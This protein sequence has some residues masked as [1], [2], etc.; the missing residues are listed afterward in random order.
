MVEYATI[1]NLVNQYLYGQLD[2][3]SDLRARLRDLP[4]DAT[5]RL[6]VQTAT[7]MNSVGR[8]AVPSRAKAVQDFFSGRIS[9]SLGTT[10]GNGYTRLT[11]ADAIARGVLSGSDLRIEVSNYFTDPGS[12]DY[13]ER[14]FIWGGTSYSIGLETT[15]VWHEGNMF[16]ENMEV[17]PRIPENFDFIASNQI[18]QN[19]NETILEPAID[20]YRIG[21]KV[22]LDFDGT[23]G[24]VYDGY[25]DANFRLDA[26]RVSQW[27][28][29]TPADGLRATSEAIRLVRELIASGAIEYVRDDKNIIYDSPRDDVLSPSDWKAPPYTVGGSSGYIFVAGKGDDRVTGSAL[30]DVVYGGD[31]ADSVL[32]GSGDD[33][34]YGGDQDDRLLG[35]AGKDE[36]YG[37]DGDDFLDGGAD[38]DRLFGGKDNDLISGG[39]GDDIINGEDG[40]DRLL[41]DNGR[42]TIQGGAGDDLIA[43]GD[44]DDTI[45]GGSGNDRITGD[46]GDDLVAGGTGD[47]IIVGDFG[48]DELQ[49]GADNDM[50][51][52]GA[53]NDKLFG[54]AGRDTLLGGDNSD[55]LFGG[56]GDDIL[57]GGQS[58]DSFNG[59]E[60]DDILDAA[61]DDASMDALRG[62]SGRDTFIVNDGDVILDLERGDKGVVIAGLGLRGGKRSKNDSA[63]LY[64]GSNGDTYLLRGS[65]LTVSARGALITIQ[66]FSNGAGGIK[67][68]AKDPN[69]DKKKAEDQASPIVVDLDGDGIELV[70]LAQSNVVFDVDGDG[71]AERT[72]WVGRDD[73][74]LV[75]DLGNDG[76]IADASEIFGTTPRGRGGVDT[77]DFRSGFDDLAQFDSDGDGKISSADA[78]FGE[79]KIWRD[80][81]QDG[82]SDASEL[83][84][85]TEVGIQSLDLNYVR[86]NRPLSDGNTLFDRSRATRSDGTTVEVSDVFFAVDR[87][88]QNANDIDV[89]DIDPGVVALPFLIGQGTVKDLDVAMSGDPLLKQM[90]SDLAALDAGRLGEFMP[91]VMDIVLRWTGADKADVEGRGFNVN[92]QWMAALE[93][94]TGSPFSQGGTPNPRPNAGSISNQSINDFFGYAAASLFVQL[95]VAQ[96]AL[97]GMKFLGGTQIEVDLGTTLASL[98]S[99]A[100]LKAPTE[101]TDK[102]AYWQLVIRTLETAAPALGV[103]NAAIA[104]AISPE[105]AGF[106]YEQVRSAIWTTERSPEAIG[107]GGFQTGF[108]P[109]T[110]AGTGLGAEY[111]DNLHVIRGGNVEIKDN[112]GSDT[113]YVGSR[114]VRAT[115]TDAVL[116]YSDTA[117]SQ[118]DTL[119]FSASRYED[120][121]FSVGTDEN[122]DSLLVV[123][124][125]SRN[126]AISIKRA[127][128]SPSFFGNGNVATAI[129]KFVF[130]D[131]ATKDIGEIAADVGVL[132]ATPYEDILYA[133]SDGS[134]LDGL[135]GNDLLVGTSNSNAF[136]LRA[137]GDHDQISDKFIG[138]TDRLVIDA[139][140]GT[141]AFTLSNDYDRRD[142]TVTLA[143]GESVT[144]QNQNMN[145]SRVIQRFVFADGSELNA[146][147]ATAL[148]LNATARDETII[149]TAVADVIV[150]QG[151]DDRLEG[152]GGDD[153]YVVDANSGHD[154][155]VDRGN[156]VVRF[157]G[158]AFS[159]VTVTRTGNEDRDIRISF[160]NAAASLTLD[161]AVSRSSREGVAS[162]FV[163]S[164]GVYS[165]E[166]VL[167][168]AP[169]LG[170]S[171]TGTDLND[172][173]VGTVGDDV[174]DGRAGNDVLTDSG[175]SDRY[176]FGRGSGA[177]IIRDTGFGN[178]AIVL[179]SGISLKDLSF[180][181]KNGG[182]RIVLNERDNL[183]LEGYFAGSTPA[184]EVLTIE[185]RT[186]SLTTISGRGGYLDPPLV[187]TAGDDLIAVNP[188]YYNRSARLN[189][190]GG[191]DV[192]ADQATDTTI[193]L[194]ANFGTK[195]VSDGD[196]SDTIEF[197]PGIS[198]DDVTLSRDDRDLVITVGNGGGTVIWKHYFEASATGR[199]SMVDI[200]DGVI[201]GDPGRGNRVLEQLVFADGTRID[202]DR[203]DAQFIASTAGNDLILRQDTLDGGGG[204]DLLEGDGG[205]NSYIFGR[206]YGH[207]I[208]RDYESPDF[209][210]SGGGS[211]SGYGYGYGNQFTDTVI[212]DGLAL[213]D[214]VL[215]RT[216][217]QGEDLKFTVIAT[218]AT[219]T[220]DREHVRSFD[221][222]TTGEIEYFSFTDAYLSN[223]ELTALIVGTT[224]GDDNI[225]AVSARAVIDTLG[226]GD[227]VEAGRLGATVLVDSKTTTDTLRFASA[228][229]SVA[230]GLS[231]SIADYAPTFL[232]GGGTITD[233]VPVVRGDR[234]DLVIRFSGGG[235]L[236][237]EGGIAMWLADGNY[238]S[239]LGTVSFLDRSYDARNII[240][241]AFRPRAG[242]PFDD[243]IMGTRN[244]DVIDATAGNDAIFTIGGTTADTVL[245]GRGDGHDVVDTSPFNIGS[246]EGRL[247]IQLKAGIRRGDV[248]FSATSDGLVQ[249]ELDGGVDTLSFNPSLGDPDVSGVLQG[250]TTIVF[251]DGTTLDASSIVD[252]LSR[253]TAGNDVII[254]D[255]RT[256]IVDGGAGDDVIFLSN[257]GDEFRFGR[258]SG[259]DTIKRMAGSQAVANLRFGIG[260]SLGNLDFAF[261]GGDE[262]DLVISISGSNDRLTIEDF[263]S[264]PTG[265]AASVPVNQFAFSDGTVLSWQ[266]IA[267]MT[268]GISNQGDDVVHGNV[269]G[270][271][272]AGGAGN[273]LLL[274][275]GGDDLYRFGRGDQSDTIVDRGGSADTIRFGTNIYPANAIFSRPSD[276]PA[277]LLIEIDGDERLTLTVRG[278]F[279]DESSRIELFAFEDGTVLG[280]QDVQ[281]LIL[282]DSITRGNDARILGYNGD[283][284]IDALSGDDFV[285]G[286]KG[287]DRLEGGTGIDTADFSGTF[288]QYRIERDGNDWIVTDLV[289]GRDGTDRLHGFEFVRFQGWDS[290]QLDTRPVAWS[291]PSI[292]LAGVEDTRL[293]IDPNSILAQVVNPDGAALSIAFDDSANVWRLRDGSYAA[294]PPRDLT[295]AW[296]VGYSV[297]DG[298]GNAQYGSV[299][300]NIVPINDA[301][302]ARTVQVFGIEDQVIEGTVGVTDADGDT[303]AYAIAQ[304][305]NH[306]TV[307]LDAATGAYVYTPSTD[308]NGGDSFTVRVTDTAGT[309]SVSSIVVS[310]EPVNDAPLVARPLL[311]QSSPEDTAID[312]VIPATS[313][314]DVD[315][316]A[317][318][319]TATLP[320]GRPLPSWLT[321]NDSTA[322]FTGTPP[323]N[324]NGFIDVK[325][326]ASDG[327][328]SAA[329]VF[330]LTTTPVN[331]APVVARTLADVA[332]LED[333]AIDFTVPAASFTDVDGDTLTLSA[334]LTSGAPLPVWLAFDPTTSRFTGTPPANYNGVFD[335]RV[336]ASDG[337]LSAFDDFRLTVTPVNDAPAL[338]VALPDKTSPEDASIDFTLP[339]GSFSDVDGDVLTLSAKLVGGGA[340][341]SWLSFN[342]ATTRFAGTPPANFNGFVDVRVTARDGALTTFD[343]FR[344]TVTPVNDAPVAVNDSGFSVATGS[345][346]TIAPVALLANDGDVD[347]DPLTITAVGGA[348]GG[349]VALNGSGQIVFTPTLAAAGAGSFTYTISD[350]SLTANASVA[351]QI[352]GSINNVITGT[353]GN[354]SLT[355]LANVANTIDGLAGN[356][357]INGGNLNDILYGRAG[358]DTINGNAGNDTIDGGDGNDT[359]NAGDGDD[360]VLGGAGNDAISGGSGNDTLSAGDGN[361]TVDAGAGNDAA[362]GGI[363]NDVLS[364]GAGNDLIDGGDGNDTLTGDDGND[365][366]IGGLGNDTINGGAGIDT[367]DYS[368][369]TANLTV[370]LA[371]TTGQTVS[372]GDIDTISNA[373]N[374]TGG[375]GADT[376]TGS[377]L[378]NVLNGGTGND[379]LTGGAGNDTI[380]GGVGTADIAVF[381]GLQA[382]YTIATTNGVVTV[383]DNQSATDGDDGTDTISGI[384]KVEF[385]GGLQQSVTSPIVLDLNSDGVNLVHNNNTNVTFDWNRDGRRDQTGWID[386]S[387]AF[388]VCDRDGNGTVSGSD[389]LSFVDDKRAAKSDLDGL[390]AFDSNSDG[391]LSGGD[392]RFASFMVWQD[393]NGNGIA[394]QGEVRSLADAGIASISLA[395]T[396]VNRNWAWGDNLT[397]NTGSFTRTDGSTGALSD[398]ALSYNE[399]LGAFKSGRPIVRVPVFGRDD[400]ASD[401]GGNGFLND[402][403]NRGI[404]DAFGAAQQLAQAMSSF[405]VQSGIDAGGFGLSENQGIDQFAGVDRPTHHG[406]LQTHYQ[407]A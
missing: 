378:G 14:A 31:G 99:S 155:I 35:Q 328:L 157:D 253:G 149:G 46:G 4:T 23:S 203:I 274:G 380:I 214:V 319:F 49:G 143:T 185:D 289:L 340:L 3:P 114:D 240:G 386:G 298:A 366:I 190:K 291:L 186:F 396:A 281:R 306:G 83:K 280:W 323:A 248:T 98:L 278:Q 10:D 39:D 243:V 350:G 76:I 206:D 400:F 104:A 216:G 310:L 375:S 236:T 129:E 67:L 105:L 334:K 87:T 15:L 266:T 137:G 11:L 395:G 163:F 108:N 373:E 405:G 290:R 364:G 352:T 292:S 276:N 235:S 372:T 13:A 371:L 91:R 369:A 332:S 188:S 41:G 79:L 21:R 275:A 38:N 182:L 349:S 192:I 293:S 16:I 257:G 282:A 317:L 55:R 267:N 146:N 221:G 346:V 404:T 168:A 30:D 210:F 377:T 57:I 195:I 205:D 272:L 45:Q 120:L 68:I 217:D 172:D 138:D 72:A 122:G 270:D 333:T 209:R 102:V 56:T 258:G 318:T 92:G 116:T 313:F 29:F 394:D 250:A 383:K 110:G 50:I 398:V 61:Q 159:N 343:D 107:N 241:S 119:R 111:S 388:L 88:T 127:F 305:P 1:E 81:N 247:R 265:A 144:I 162:T 197:A 93:A 218:G 165:F 302:I 295:G 212:F 89:G 307:A 228:S 170:A 301:P 156:N 329:N 354:D 351:V 160:A 161:D 90:V 73:G 338:T 60:G 166:Q 287:N 100:R 62:G 245:F 178:D 78:R 407:I 36:I 391:K 381:A 345:S 326:T 382:S 262:H 44:E 26:L 174:I 115:I 374:L 147:A 309:S 225:R 300:F 43:G 181:Y 145:D 385:K 331:D 80:A 220:V 66:N 322:R 97:P 112:R 63:G 142:L 314:T 204:D 179:R 117:G 153:I 202:S 200:G 40:N 164:D 367:V 296:T 6:T 52:G 324:Y 215:S 308:F 130:A 242:T 269:G 109:L 18:I 348:V 51:D 222:A 226:G 393:K 17:R 360:S 238:G 5:T 37:D 249:L 361:D 341:P 134:V 299:T 403:S 82:V 75:Q 101:G 201:I 25:S 330:R 252:M 180:D 255:D 199:R 251:A 96:Q 356:D 28:E 77:G 65:T 399:A 230:G 167:A 152:R 273:D 177:D 390:T 187:G 277:D 158:I 42:D 208:I 233:F 70:A 151:G 224:E 229:D 34:L 32:A 336:T 260:L 169:F 320:D 19:I 71:I 365:T 239:T 24:A 171:I 401:R 173:L 279:A 344:L 194:D 207:D 84:T 227:I 154:T 259:I 379:R 359:I 316:D 74:L 139:L 254:G 231:V 363:G 213:N 141:V 103:S 284:A 131:G 358:N 198:A 370:S 150:G 327:D 136:A 268:R 69:D 196:G 339:A 362:T 86:L 22:W 189:P 125:T 95:P 176:L 9:S 335:V 106:T 85:L 315:R 256:Q 94:L 58:T 27:N 387:D 33:K 20:P 140:P 263:F 237:V 392:A 132:Q 286:G 223:D 121:T 376:L 148:A 183:L 126:I 264:S 355:G 325:V 357:V 232:G 384:E 193:V 54:N 128:G 271:V 47:D 342:P 135:A 368:Y 311:D 337:T 321:F 288:N 397:I 48:N 353:P 234:I 285:S 294:Q 246:G 133:K 283:E 406:A 7:F 191:T 12:P 312:F 219:L 64:T 303:L 347:G 389:E 402:E 261:G 59:E 123:R 124:D 2:T 113:Y 184:I 297:T 118:K 53:G 211:E 175:G 244:A 304:T 8:Y